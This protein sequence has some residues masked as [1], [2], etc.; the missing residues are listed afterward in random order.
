M[1]GVPR[2]IFGLFQLNSFLNYCVRAASVRVV[3]VCGGAP[4]AGEEQTGIFSSL[5]QRSRP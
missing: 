1:G 3:R 2:H 5:V 4:R